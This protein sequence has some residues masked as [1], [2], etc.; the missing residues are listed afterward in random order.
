MTSIRVPTVRLKEI[1]KLDFTKELP[2]AGRMRKG[3]KTTCDRCGKPIT[4]ETFIAGFKNGMKNMK[5]HAACI[6]A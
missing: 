4:S 5:F 2:M 3:M 6:D 1:G